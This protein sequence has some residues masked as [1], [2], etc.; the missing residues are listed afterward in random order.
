MNHVDLARAL[1]KISTP[2]ERKLWHW[3]RHRYLHGYKFRRQHPVGR[4]ILDFYCPVLRLCIEVDGGV[5]DEEAKRQRDE[6]RTKELEE[7][8]I[9][10]LRLRNEYVHD[11]P[12]GAWEC[13]VAK[14][15]ELEAPHPSPLPAW[16][17]EGT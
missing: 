6:M 13:I 2:T 11:Q 8:G 16:R 17:G 4:Y 3:L 14:V 7:L 15:R 10:V 9:T 1:R 12:D 5:H